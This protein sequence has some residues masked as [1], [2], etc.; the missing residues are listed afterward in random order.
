MPQLLRGGLAVIGACV[1]LFLCVVGCARIFRRR[2]PAPDA[3]GPRP[4]YGAM[5]PHLDAPIDPSRVYDVRSSGGGR[6]DAVRFLGW[7]RSEVDGRFLLAA[8]DWVVLGRADG[9]RV[10][11][12]PARVTAVVEASDHGPARHEADS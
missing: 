4:L 11:L 5:L 1:A 12:D 9:R 8:R 10:L 3:R 7:T 6:F 2:R